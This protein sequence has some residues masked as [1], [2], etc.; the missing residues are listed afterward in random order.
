MGLKYICA[1]CF[2]G[3]V[4]HTRSKTTTF[5][6]SMSMGREGGTTRDA[7]DTHGHTPKQKNEN[8]MCMETLETIKTQ[9]EHMFGRCFL[10]HPVQGAVHCT[11][12][13]PI[14]ANGDVHCMMPQPCYPNPILRWTW[15]GR[16][17][18]WGAYDG[19]VHSFLGFGV[20]PWVSPASRVV[21]PSRP[22]D[23]DFVSGV[24][25]DRVWNDLF[26]PKAC[27]TYVLQPDGDDISQNLC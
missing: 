22:M 16:G 4:V 1:A 11:R 5:A 20:F 19:G 8:G 13:E 12:R 14:D 18:Q 17:Y 21:P 26:S 23:I 3:N 7:S 25:F 27:R 15:V 2:R 24:F 10:T 6:N 9:V